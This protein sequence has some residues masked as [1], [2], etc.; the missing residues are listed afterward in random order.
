VTEE[1]K[2][3]KNDADTF[4]E[5]LGGLEGRTKPLDKWEEREKAREKS[6]LDTND[7]IRRQ[8]E[9]AILAMENDTARADRYEEQHKAEWQRNA[10][11]HAVYLAEVKHAQA[12]REREVAA[13]ERISD[14]LETLTKQRA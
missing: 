8:H 14:A 1:Q 9:R 6:V 3:H 5:T 13:F 11:N 2:Q 12:H 10:E 7:A 4:A